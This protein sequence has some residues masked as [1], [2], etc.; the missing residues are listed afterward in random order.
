MICIITRLLKVSLRLSTHPNRLSTATVTVAFGQFG[1]VA[2]GGDPFLCIKIFARDLVHD[3]SSR[4]GCPTNDG[5]PEIQTIRRAHRVSSGSSRSGKG[6]DVELRDALHESHIPD[7]EWNIS[8]TG[9][10]CM[11]GGSNCTKL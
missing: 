1:A 2:I 3:L 4:R 9:I 10:V 8:N 11:Y 6:C 5:R 7:N